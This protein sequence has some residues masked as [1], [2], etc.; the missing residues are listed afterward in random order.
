M[1]PR[2][3]EGAQKELQRIKELF[4]RKEREGKRL[5]RAFKALSKKLSLIEDIIFS[6]NPLQP[7]SVFFRSVLA[8]LQRTVDA[9]AGSIFLKN[10]KEELF[11]AVVTGPKA[12]EIRAHKYTI[13]RGEGLVGWV[14]SSGQ[15]LVVHD[16]TRDRR[17]FKKISD[18]VGYEVKDIVCV[19]IRTRREVIGAIELLNK[20]DAAPFSSEDLELLE[21][22][23]RI[24]GRLV[25]VFKRI[26]R[27]GET[28]AFDAGH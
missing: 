18:E 15:P 17:F 19:P 27:F 8:T 4:L 25:E 26:E 22:V 1:K 24:I 7:P 23:G 14:V 11:F 5:Y 2:R 13:P 6:F 12:E 28:D 21:G 20:K 16:A 9:D 10:E 3:I